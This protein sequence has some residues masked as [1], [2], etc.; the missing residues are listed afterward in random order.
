ML[1][2]PRLYEILIYNLNS[3]KCKHF[4]SFMMFIFQADYD[5]LIKCYLIFFSDGI[6]IPRALQRTFI[7]EK[8]IWI[9]TI[10]SCTEILIN[11]NFYQITVMYGL[12]KVLW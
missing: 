3:C 7:M 6:V 1:S 5:L 9:C 12:L 10:S 8:D 4:M 11:F 2:K